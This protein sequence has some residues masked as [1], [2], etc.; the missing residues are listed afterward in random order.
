MIFFFFFFW[1]QSCT[2]TQAGVQWCDLHSLQ[3]PPPRFKQLSCLSLP[4]SWVYRPLP[5]C[6][7][8]FFCIFSRDRVSLCWL[9]RSRT[10]DLV[11]RLPRP[12]KVL[13]LHAWVTAPGQSLLY[14]LSQA[15]LR[16]FQIRISRYN[17]EIDNHWP[18]GGG[19]KHYIEVTWVL[20]VL[21]LFHAQVN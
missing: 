11:I 9:G 8:N 21:L 16:T 14:I 4:S 3:P 10:P 20:S 6:L 5:P 12:P 1:R 2:A 15:L 7:A 18:L 13:G 17:T 19:I